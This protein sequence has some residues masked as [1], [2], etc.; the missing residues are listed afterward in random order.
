MQQHGAL[1]CAASLQTLHNTGQGALHVLVQV[2]KQ[3]HFQT[4]PEIASAA[5]AALPPTAA[6]LATCKPYN[7]YNCS[8][9]SSLL[10]L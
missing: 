2:H 7:N 6:A 9:P 5:A 4:S 8:H 10:T 1:Y 3:A